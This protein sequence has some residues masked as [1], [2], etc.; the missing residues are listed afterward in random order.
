MKSA[1]LREI[2][3][4]IPGKSECGHNTIRRYHLYGASEIITDIDVASLRWV[5]HVQRMKDNEMVK[6]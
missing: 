5:G 4:S 6:R 1:I 2:N 3:G